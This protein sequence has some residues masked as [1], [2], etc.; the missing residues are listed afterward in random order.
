MYD[1]DALSFRVV[2]VTGALFLTSE[3]FQL[4]DLI[5]LPRYST[6]GFSNKHTQGIPHHKIS[7]VPVT[8]ASD[9][10]E[11]T[12]YTSDLWSTLVQKVVFCCSWGSLGMSPMCMTHT[13]TPPV[14]FGQVSGPF[15]RGSAQNPA[16]KSTSG[17]GAIQGPVSR[18]VS[19]IEG[20]SRS[21]L[22]REDLSFAVLCLSFVCPLFV[23]CLFFCCPFWGFPDLSGDFPDLSFFSFL[24]HEQ[25]LR[26]RTRV[27]D[28]I[29]T[30]PERSGKP[31]GLE[32]S[33]GTFSQAIKKVSCN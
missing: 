9:I 10:L 33:R 28:T 23:L 30:F 19:S 12:K 11:S 14:G 22:I 8:R 3:R 21:G 1:F 32:T 24:A 2:L 13:R 27:C 29:R 20:V 5:V 7:G 16:I 6:Q 15:I 4:G 26:E 25:H 31:P 18:G 17:I